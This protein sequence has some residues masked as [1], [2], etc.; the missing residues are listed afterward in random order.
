M[1]SSLRV[2]AVVL[3]LFGLL[4]WLLLHSVG[5]QGAE[6]VFAQRDVARVSL[7]EAG[8]RWDVLQACA[9]LQKNYDPLVADIDELRR[10]ALELRQ[11]A[12]IRSSDRGLLDELVRKVAQDEV[13]LGRFKTDNALLQNSLA[14]FDVLDSQLATVVDPRVSAAITAVGNSVLHLTHDPS[15]AVQQAVRQRLDAVAAL[16]GGIGDTSLSR[17]IN[18]LVIHGRI[19]SRLLPGVDEDLR[20]LSSISTY[21]LRQA[22]RASQ[23]ARRLIEEAQA[24]RF[25]LALFAVAIVLS[26]MLVRLGLQRR[27]GLRLLRERVELK[28]I[29]AELSTRFIACPLDQHDGMLD[30][31]LSRLGPAFG[32]D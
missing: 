16:A 3:P 7:S 26:A 14:Y 11:Q 9:G 28:A 19:L 20:T 32:A 12:M 31:M 30:E 10:S 4:T 23:D 2:A 18:L 22:I 25:R 13:A 21:D 5:P 24:A 6:Y 8:L 15:A 27:A 17:Q 1:K 29:I